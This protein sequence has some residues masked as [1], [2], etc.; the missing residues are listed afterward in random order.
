MLKHG[1]VLSEIEEF[2]AQFK[3]KNDSEKVDKVANL[4]G[5]KRK[6]GESD[7]SLSDR[8]LQHMTTFHKS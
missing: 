2:A 1:Y 7:E 5:L 3:A 6:D 4:Y 8:I